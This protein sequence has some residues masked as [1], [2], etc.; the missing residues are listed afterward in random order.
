MRWTHALQVL[1]SAWRQCDPAVL[2]AGVAVWVLRLVVLTPTTLAADPQATQEGLIGDSPVP[3][4]TVSAATGGAPPVEWLAGA[5]SRA[6]YVPVVVGGARRSDPPVGGQQSAVVTGRPGGAAPS[7]A[8]LRVPRPWR[9]PW[10][11]TRAPGSMP[12]PN[13]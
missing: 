12:P 4:A 8:I 2:R 13:A 6:R 5:A 9:I 11:T 7:A 10:P 1:S 3:V